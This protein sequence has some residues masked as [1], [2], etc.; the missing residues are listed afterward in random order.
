[1][2]FKNIGMSEA[3][4]YGVENDKWMTTLGEFINGIFIWSLLF[5]SIIY[6]TL[7]VCHLYLLMKR[8]DRDSLVMV[9]IFCLAFVLFLI[10]LCITLILSGNGKH[11][12]LWGPADTG[13]FFVSISSLLINYLI[14]SF[15]LNNS[16]VLPTT[17]YFINKKN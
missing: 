5:Q 8:K 14:F 7:F 13:L 10:W 11:D 15:N 2:T 4:Y 1:M 12:L 6:F 17:L 3:R 9:K 16:I